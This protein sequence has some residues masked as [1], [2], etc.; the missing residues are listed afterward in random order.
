MIGPPNIGKAYLFWL[1]SLFGF[2]GL[3]RFYLGRPLT[4]VLYLI[5]GGLLGLGTLYDAFHMRRLVRHARLEW[6]FEHM[7]DEPEYRAPAP[8]PTPTEKRR[9][10]RR[11][12][13]AGVL[14][15]EIL[16][17]A[18]Q[19]EGVVAAARVALASSVSVEEAR[20]ALEKLVESRDAEL[21]VTRDGGLVYVFPEF[22]TPNTQHELDS[23]T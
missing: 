9:R 21:R 7:L 20:R 1:P 4:G 22:L 13:R 2:A 12:P 5:T 16:A 18:E 23:L 17:L 19:R 14:E 3:Q 11:K 15:L 6:R 10:S 8:T